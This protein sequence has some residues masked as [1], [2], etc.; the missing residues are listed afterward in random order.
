MGSYNGEIKGVDWKIEPVKID[1]VMFSKDISK[2][3]D[4]TATFDLVPADKASYLTFYATPSISTSVPAEAYEISNVRFGA[5]D[6]DHNFV[7]SAEAGKKAGIQ[8]TITFKSSNYVLQASDVDEP[9]SALTYT[10]YYDANF[11]IT[12]A[13]AP[14]QTA[15]IE[16]YI[17]ND[18]AK[19]YA[20]DLE[21]LLP[22]L[23]KPLKYGDIRYTVNTDDLK[24]GY[25]TSGAA[26]ENGR[27]TL[28]INRVST[29]QT[30]LSAP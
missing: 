8:F 16:L 23:T 13:P 21:G 15:M 7:P 19:T 26:V 20:V 6:A 3:Y 25:C 10:Q 29:D 2:T 4:G 11:T 12:K 14:A 5:E 18:L 30:V 28:P 27:L 1:H 24:E 17:T 22:G 9:A